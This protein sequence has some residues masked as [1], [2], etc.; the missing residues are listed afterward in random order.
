MQAA[1]DKFSRCMTG[2]PSLFFSLLTPAEVTIGKFTAQ[3][4]IFQQLLYSQLRVQAKNKTLA[5]P[6]ISDIGSLFIFRFQMTRKGL[7]ATVTVTRET[8]RWDN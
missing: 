7:L 8:R 3:L 2:N 5:E 6:L 4:L 1:R